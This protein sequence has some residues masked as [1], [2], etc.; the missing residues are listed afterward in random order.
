MKNELMREEIKEWKKESRNVRRNQGIKENHKVSTSTCTERKDGTFEE[1][2]SEDFL[3][4]LLSHCDTHRDKIQKTSSSSTTLKSTQ[5]QAGK[6]LQEVQ[7]H[8]PQHWDILQSIVLF[9][10]GFK[11]PY[12]NDN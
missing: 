9:S 10:S 12:S 8:F 4:E 5:Q 7:Q 6:T 11:S 1:G 3:F 2:S